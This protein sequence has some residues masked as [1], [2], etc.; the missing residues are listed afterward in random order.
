MED[1][2]SQNLWE[3]FSDDSRLVFIGTSFLRRLL[4]PTEVDK[5][6]SLHGAMKDN[7]GNE[8]K[9][10][11]WCTECS[12]VCESTLWNAKCSS[13]AGHLALLLIDLGKS[14]NMRLGVR[15]RSLPRGTEERRVGRAVPGNAQPALMSLWGIEERES[16]H[17]T[18]RSLA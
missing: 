13:N 6:G 7:F 2:D 11:N 1:W 17:V 12:N 14:T 10:R 4:M 18:A 16:V 8:K 3:I 15:M 9:E 5:N